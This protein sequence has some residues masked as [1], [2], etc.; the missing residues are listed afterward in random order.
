[1]RYFWEH[2]ATS[3]DGLLHAGFRGA[4]GVV[5]E[6]YSGLGTSYWAAQGLIALLIPATDP[7]WTEVERPMPADGGEHAITIPGA[8]MVVRVRAD[9]EARLYP[10]S[11]P[12]ARSHDHWQRGVK[13][14]QHA[15]SSYLGWCALGEG[16]DL[17]AGLT[18]V[19]LDG[20]QWS[21]RDHARALSIA[22]DHVA[23]A[24]YF[25][26]DPSS[27]IALDD[28]Y[29]VTTHT[30]MSG[31]GEV[32]VFWHNSPEPLFLHLG[33]YGIA[34]P[35]T[36]AV[37]AT[38]SA[39]GIE[40]RT[41]G[42]YSVLRVLLGPAGKV[43]PEVLSPRKGWQNAHLFDRV[44]AFPQWRST[45]PVP[46]NVPVVIYVDGGRN[47]EPLKPE[48]S[49]ERMPGQLIIHFDGKTQVIPAVW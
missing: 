24:Y 49:I 2:G 27:K 17:G 9:G 37:T 45:A 23:S 34:A 48:F 43:S 30:L 46:A 20:R 1:L 38:G 28:R 6:F 13:Y 39:D 29:E 18:G 41:P 11:Q 31:A 40:I 15:Y 16:S 21:F 10:V 33:G 12:F 42:Y 47:R 7:F 26:L 32:H 36:E 44:G 14:E 22:E 3:D 5:A 4:N 8:G 35:S 19:S 25:E